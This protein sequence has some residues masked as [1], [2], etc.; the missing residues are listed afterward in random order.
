NHPGSGKPL[1]ETAAVGA[2]GAE[3]DDRASPNVLRR[4]DL[5]GTFGRDE[6]KAFLERRLSLEGFRVE[7]L[8]DERC[9]D[10]LV[11]DPRD[12]IARRSRHE[13]DPNV[14]VLLSPR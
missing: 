9:L 12:Q 3:R 10:L 11:K 2:A 6:H 14:R 5:A 13:L 1:L 7:W 8:G 4:S